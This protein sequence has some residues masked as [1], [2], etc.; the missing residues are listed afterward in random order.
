[1]SLGA[2][3]ALIQQVLGQY[4][5]GVNQRDA[6]LWGETW[7][8]DASWQLFDPEPVRGRDA[9]VAAWIE[10]MKGFPFVV[11]NATMGTVRID[12]ARASGT[13]YTFEVAETAAGEPIR[14]WGRYDD[15]YVKRDGVWRYAHRAF[16]VLK[17]EAGQP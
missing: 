3:L 14:V 5:D 16:T 8:E 11:M 17:S 2:E 13:S 4:I 12:G 6:Q 9:I 7:D 1:M 10:A 15:S